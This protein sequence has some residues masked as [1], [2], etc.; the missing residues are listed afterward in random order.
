MM[1]HKS[2]IRD[3]GCSINFKGY[4]KDEIIEKYGMVSEIT[5]HHKSFR[6]AC[7]Q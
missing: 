4:T 5:S 7:I 3:E 1:A 6:I 2:E